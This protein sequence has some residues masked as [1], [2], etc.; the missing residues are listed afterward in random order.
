M[1]TPPHPVPWRF[2]SRQPPRR[3]VLALVCALML[4]PSVSTAQATPARPLPVTDS[5][6]AVTTACAV[7]QAIRPAA[8]RGRC[9]C[10][11]ERYR[12]TS[13]EYIVRV[14]EQALSGAPRLDFEQSEVRLSKTEPSVTVTRVPEL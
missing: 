10:L 2:R 1:D 5:A 7:V 6:H 11:V 4:L 13:T 14:R 12:E 3:V 8:Q 9:R